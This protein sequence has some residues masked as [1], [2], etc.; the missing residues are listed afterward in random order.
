MR[1]ASPEEK[2]AAALALLSAAT[3]SAW[4]TIWFASPWLGA[5]AAVL[6]L[7]IPALIFVRTL[8]R[9]VAMLICALAREI[10]EAHGGRVQLANRRGGGLTVTLAFPQPERETQV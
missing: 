10:A 7:A 4:A 8:A 1:L 3:L 5:A 9:P 2:L 6:A